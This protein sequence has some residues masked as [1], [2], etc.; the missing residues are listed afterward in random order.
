M[1]SSVSASSLGAEW[2]RMAQTL[3]VI[4]W[5]ALPDGS[6]EFVN[7]R[8][9]EITG[10][11]PEQI[12]GRTGAAI[13][14]PADAARVGAEYAESIRSGAPFRAELRVRYADG[15]YHWARSESDPLRDSEGNIVR[16]LGVMMDVDEAHEANERFGLLGEAIPMLV[17]TAD[18]AG[19]VDWY[20][21]RY[22][23]YTG[24]SPEEA[25]GWGWQAAHHP[26]DFLEVM[27]RWPASLESGDPFHME[28]RLRGRD[29]VFN[30]FLAKIEPHRN[31]R[32]SIDRWYGSLMNIQLQKEAHH[33]SKRVAETLQDVFLPQ[34]FPRRPNLRIDATYLAAERDALVGGDWYDAFELPDGTLIFSIGDVA[35]HGLQ[36]SV[37]VGRIRQAILTLAFRMNDPAQILDEVDRILQY[38]QPDTFVTALVA[39]VD[40]SMERMRYAG[41]GHP[42][43]LLARPG[44]GV[45]EVLPVGGLPLGCPFDV[46]RDVHE[47]TIETDNVIA[48]YTDGITEFSHDPVAAEQRL[49]AAVAML[50]GNTT[51][52]HPATAVRGLVFDD[53]PAR[54]DAALM[55]LQF[56]VIDHDRVHHDADA[57]ERLWRFHSSDA[58]TAHESRKEIA[59]FLRSLAA[60]DE[61][62]F[63]SELIVGEIL[64]NTVEHA[65]GIVEVE[66]DW[67]REQPAIC[68]RDIGPGLHTMRPGLPLDPLDENGRGLY[69]IHA[70]AIDVAIRAMAGYGTEIRATL[71]LRRATL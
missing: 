24:Q 2:M 40:P 46:P 48:F 68:V 18:A 47:V 41:A 27:R 44:D 9:E 61:D 69:L 66:I 67:S 65:P 15:S 19:R 58:H 6:V 62:T 29:G 55:V 8:W 63:P 31:E 21:Q 25:L 70:L 64:A 42:P 36:A 26:D 11:P 4:I 51:M 1:K 17:F 39:F 49:R 3:P 57:F 43:P 30:W 45:A 38:Q 54:D 52:L 59:A 23:E 20:N 7:R 35:G 28:F 60:P 71:P 53:Q 5:A 34:Q 33:R 56:S 13:V 22:Y 14:H 16:W 50:V 37:T 12:L 10:I 32:G